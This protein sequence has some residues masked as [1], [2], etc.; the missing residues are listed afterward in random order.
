LVTWIIILLIFAAG[1]CC[2]EVFI[3]GFGVCGIVGGILLLISV[4]L[5]IIFI[6]YGFVIILLENCFVAGAVFFT[7]R[8]LAGKKFCS[9]IILNETLNE[10]KAD[11]GAL[12]YLLGKNGVSKTPLK[13]FGKAEFNGVDMEVCSDGTFIAKD[14]RVKVIEVAQN[15]IIVKEF[16]EGNSNGI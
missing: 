10:E 11:I 8:S 2:A 13:P 6:P 3:P 4:V 15:K 12:N 16:K 1:L 7:I 5:T 9:K 14:R